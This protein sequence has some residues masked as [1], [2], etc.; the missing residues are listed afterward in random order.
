MEVVGSCCYVPDDDPRRSEGRAPHVLS[1]PLEALAD[2]LDV[3]LP[4]IC[5]DHGTIDATSVVA[6]LIRSASLVP[7]HVGHDDEI[8]WLLT[9]AHTIALDVG[10]DEIHRLLEVSAGT[11]ADSRVL[12]MHDLR[13]DITLGD[14][15]DRRR[16]IEGQDGVLEF[17]SRELRDEKTHRHADPVGSVSVRHGGLHG[18][19]EVRHHQRA[20]ETS[21]VLCSLH[22]SVP[23]GGHAIELVYTHRASRDS[24][25]LDDLVRVDDILR[26]HGDLALLCLLEVL[27]EVLATVHAV[28]IVCVAQSMI[29]LLVEEGE[30][31]L[32]HAAT[33]DTS[34]IDLLI[35]LGAHE[36]LGG[37][38]IGVHSAHHLAVA[39]HQSAWLVDAREDDLR[40][41]LGEMRHASLTRNPLGE[42]TDWLE[43]SLWIHC[44]GIGVLIRDHHVLDELLRRH[45]DDLLVDRI[46]GCPGVCKHEEIAPAAIGRHQI[47]HR[48]RDIEAIMVDHV[49]PEHLRSCAL[50]LAAADVTV[51]EEQDPHVLEGLLVGLCHLVQLIEVR[52]NLVSGST[53][54]K[55]RVEDDTGVTHT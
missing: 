5:L 20:T 36:G 1:S 19:T 18:A 38:E 48:S 45:L 3:R 25:A 16:A 30:H 4:S 6:T 27:L 8:L 32:L 14:L 12:E 15:V 51:L 49:V 50:S 42:K 54:D 29:L 40:N 39:L 7:V 17:I 47:E 41:L 43:L 31:V 35:V 34:R 21:C 53:P 37:L 44:L 11:L 46:I 26:L 23:L 52:L 24:N 2:H 28:L 33:R 22:D 9:R 10:E 13:V 55:N